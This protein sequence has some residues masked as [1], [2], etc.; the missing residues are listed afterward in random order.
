MREGLQ[1]EV[2]RLRG[3]TVEIHGVLPCEPFTAELKKKMAELEGSNRKLKAQIPSL[4]TVAE[5]ETM[6][7]KKIACERRWQESEEKVGS[8]KKQLEEQGEHVR[9]LDAQNATLAAQQREMEAEKDQMET[10]LRDQIK[11]EKSQF[12]EDWKN[13]TEK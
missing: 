4:D 13:A 11:K 12:E 9:I 7:A 10:E 3:K 1:E 2:D 8:L 5:L 6:T